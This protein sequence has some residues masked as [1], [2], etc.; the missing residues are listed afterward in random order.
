LLTRRKLLAEI[1]GFSTLANWLADDYQLGQRLAQNG[2]RLALCP[3][4]VDCWIAP[5]NW[6]DVWQHQLRWA[7]TIRVCRP[8]P[9]FLSILS[10]ATF[11]PL[12]WL[13]VSL[14]LSKTFC[15][16]LVATACLLIRIML[17]QNLQRRLAQP[18][19]RSAPPWLVPVK[20]LLQAMVWAGAF[21][22][23]KIT[24]RGEQLKLHRDGT[25]VAEK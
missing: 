9:Y 23:N 8:V 18:G 17:A 12:L 2:Q 4:V 25:L 20:D 14:V 21:M 7:R 3:V 22:G 6:R 15:P 10:N 16:P 19:G 11:W 5:M 13:M 24:W 1:G